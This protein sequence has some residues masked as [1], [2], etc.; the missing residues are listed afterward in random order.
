[1]ASVKERKKDCRSL[2]EGNTTKYSILV[3]E[4][5]PLHQISFSEIILMS[6]RK[7]VRLWYLE[8]GCG[9]VERERE[10]KKNKREREKEEKISLII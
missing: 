9:Y 7:L 5:Q 2:P 3:P 6:F 8:E 10:R 1:M 4:T